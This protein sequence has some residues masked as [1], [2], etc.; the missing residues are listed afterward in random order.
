MG[1]T[2]QATTTRPT[3]GTMSTEQLFICS[4]LITKEMQIAMKY[5]I[6]PED[7]RAYGEEWRWILNF[8]QK[9]N[10]MPS[11]NTF[12]NTF[13]NFPL[14]VSRDTA[15]LAEELQLKKIES[16]LKGMLKETA[17]RIQDGNLSDALKYMHS[18]ALSVGAQYGLTE[19]GDIFSD[20]DDIMAKMQ[21]I[22]DRA[23]ETGSSGIPLGFHAYDSRT[24]GAAPGQLV[25]IAARLGVGKSWIG[26]QWARSAIKAGYTVI[27]NSLEMPRDQMFTRMV[28]LFAK[29]GG[30]LFSNVDLAQGKYDLNDFKMFMK[31]LHTQLDSKLHIIDRTRGTVT[32][33]TI[34]AQ[35][36]RLNPDIV[37]IDYIQL[38]SKTRDWAEIGQITGELKSIA[39]QYGVP[40]VQAAQLNR[41]AVGMSKKGEPPGPETLSNS[42]AIG[43]DSD[44]VITAADK[45]KRVLNLGCVKYRHGQ[46]NFKWS[47]HLDP[48]AGILKEIDYSQAVTLA[49]EDKAI[50]IAEEQA[51]S[52]GDDEDY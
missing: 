33:A 46:K 6:K 25:T 47:V 32:P 9:Q 17:R 21:L 31:K 52:A 27:Y 38:M 42:D 51:A 5:D 16:D 45:S 39:T 40:I 26:C 4:V 43:M 7:L 1:I 12:V 13:P 11:K 14:Q 10:R 18:N 34:A 19:E 49:A 20:N 30:Q 8:Y 3:S 36:E 23:A 29:E 2:R 24:G 35:I 22:Y 37:F 41:E 28:P 48:A 44:V 50:Q 15:H